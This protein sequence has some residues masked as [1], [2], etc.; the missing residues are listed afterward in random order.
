MQI[1]DNFSSFSNTD[2]S[3]PNTKS[4]V[5]RFLILL[6]LVGL[7]FLFLNNFIKKNKEYSLEKKLEIL[8]NLNNK[9]NNMSNDAQNSILN[10]LRD[11]SKNMQNDFE[12]QNSSEQDKLIILNNLRN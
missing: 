3:K 11:D 2:K 8:D 5:F 12:G 9:N 1:G 4:A 10:T 6:I 7:G